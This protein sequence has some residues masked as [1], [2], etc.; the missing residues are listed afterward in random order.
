[1]V[2]AEGIFGHVTPVPYFLH[3]NTRN[4]CEGPA[5]SLSHERASGNRRWLAF[6]P[7]AMSCRGGCAAVRWPEPP[8]AGQPDRSSRSKPA[9]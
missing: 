4:A 9:G 8:A 6:V 1:M 2:V 3:N 7:A 5:R